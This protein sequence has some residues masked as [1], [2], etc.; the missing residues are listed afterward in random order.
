MCE[1]A[2]ITCITNATL[3]QTSFILILQAREEIPNT[4]TYRIEWLNGL[5]GTQYV[6]YITI[7]FS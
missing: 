2:K 7:L 4:R 5:D 3:A 6:K 1:L